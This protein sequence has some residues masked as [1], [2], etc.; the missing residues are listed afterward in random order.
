MN[1][2]ITNIKD[3]NLFCEEYE[4]KYIIWQSGHKLTDRDALVYEGINYRWKKKK[5]V[6][7][8]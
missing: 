4:P 2:L 3:Y 7:K 6:D 5:R 8:K 1:L